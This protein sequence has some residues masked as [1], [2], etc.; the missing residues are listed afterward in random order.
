MSAASSVTV[1]GLGSMGS[2]QARALIR[3]G[4][5]VTVWNRTSERAA[6]LVSEGAALARTPAE[7]VAASPLGIMCV[8]DYAAADAILAE[9]GVASAISGKT[10]VQLTTGVPAQVYAQQAK[11]RENGGHFLAGGI[12]AYP[13]S[14]GRPN[15]LIVYAGD[16]IFEQHRA[17]LLSLAGSSQ[18]LGTDP[19][20]AIGAYFALSSYMISTLAL[21]FET[22]AVSRHYGISIDTYYSLARIVTDEILEG[23]RDGAHRV[24]TGDFDGKLASIDLTIAGM[25]EVC[26]TFR[27]T[28]MPVKMTEA[29]VDALKIASAD[30]AGNDDISRLTETI[31]SHRRT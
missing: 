20:A 15:C 18:Y 30:G 29:L 3:R 22:A 13:R 10:L 1:I 23:I 6:A 5:R 14:I 16:P 28:G 2:A 12:L 4:H 19:A 8:L 27:Q 7:A 21:F 31:W 25:E 17:T 24:A 11:V 26:K 9:P